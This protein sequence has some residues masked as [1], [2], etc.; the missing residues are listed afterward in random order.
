[1][2]DSVTE[3]SRPLSPETFALDLSLGGR[4]AGEML[5]QIVPEKQAWVARVQTDFSGVLPDVRRVQT[6]RL[7]PKSLSSLGYAE[8]DGKR[9]SFETTVDS[10]AGLLTL[11]QGRDEAS[12]PLVAEIHDPVS[13]LLWLRAHPQTER[14]E[15]LMAGGRVHLRRLADAEVGGQ[16]TRVFDLR[17]GGALVYVEAAAPHRLLKLV[18]PTDFGFVDATLRAERV[19]P[20]PQR[21]PGR[22]RRR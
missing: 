19:R 11:R 4:D 14:A 1:M 15:L 12:V 9:A 3:A 7:H 13:V 21:E 5:W 2:R 8:G 22:R 10:R 16:A 20:A 17:P 18:Q 6:S